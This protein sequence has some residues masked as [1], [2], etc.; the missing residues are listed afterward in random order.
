[1][2]TAEEFKEELCTI[3]QRYNEKCNVHANAKKKKVFD[4]FQHIFLHC[5]NVTIY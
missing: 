4:Q 2:D 3:L 1:M 5:Q